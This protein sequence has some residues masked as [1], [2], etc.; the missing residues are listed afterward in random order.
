MAIDKSTFETNVKALLNT[1]KTYDGE[2]GHE[3]SDAIDKFAA[4]LADYVETII[5]SST[6]VITPIQI[7]AATLSNSGGPVVA[8]NNLNG[9]LI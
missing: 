8:A 2:T 7:T 1:L 9:T 6:V 3:P 4:D 5:K